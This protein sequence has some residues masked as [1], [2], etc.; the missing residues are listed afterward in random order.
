ML[1]VLKIQLFTD[2]VTKF[3]RNLIDETIEVREEKGVVRQDMI[4]L[5]LERRKGI[6]R[7]EETNNVDAG[8]ATAQEYSTSQGNPQAI[9]V[10]SIVQVTF[11]I[12]D[13][14]YKH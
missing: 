12:I 14:K 7:K 11:Y 5:L 2:E 4:Q 13:A 10:F 8:F 1:Q 9:S 3:F 6:E